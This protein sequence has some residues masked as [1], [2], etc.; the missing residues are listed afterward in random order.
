MADEPEHLN[1]S[2]IT[3][4]R[5]LLRALCHRSAT[6]ALQIE[7]LH[8]AG[9]QKFGDR[10]SEIVF[11]ALRQM[12]GRDS[13]DLQ[14]HLAAHLT[15]LGFPD[16]DLDELFAGAAPTEAEIRAALDRIAGARAAKS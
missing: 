10:Q 1:S 5:I 3:A 12:A 9:T 16:V 6:G 2:L 8:F 11:R 7:I 14:S 4:E 15:R 13:S